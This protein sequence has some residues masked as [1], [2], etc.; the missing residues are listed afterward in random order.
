MRTTI[1]ITSLAATAAAASVLSVLNGCEAAYDCSSP[2]VGWGTYDQTA[3]D[4]T[5]DGSNDPPDASW[6]VQSME[7]HGQRKE[8]EAWPA[9]NNTIV[10]FPM[11]EGI[12]LGTATNNSGR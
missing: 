11:K 3:L 6:L 12:P 5:V 4:K 8:P 2:G 1:H 10:V 9:I 7:G